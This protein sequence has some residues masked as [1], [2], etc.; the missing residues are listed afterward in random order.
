M[1]PDRPER[2]GLARSIVATPIGRLALTATAGGL[3]HVDLV[4]A[5]VGGVTP[6]V[7]SPVA[8]GHLRRAEEAL[9]NYFAGSVSAVDDVVVA[10]EGTDFQRAVWSALRTIPAGTTISYRQLA[11]RVGKRD[12]VR[13]VGLAN[14]RNPLPIIV[15]CHR[16]IGADR[17]LTGF[18]LGL[19][20]KAWLLVHE[21]AAE[22]FPDALTPRTVVVTR[23][24]L[25]GEDDLPAP[26]PA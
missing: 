24:I 5:D 13:A 19:A 22:P 11:E 20:V 10:P 8:A 7:G 16:V 21:G 4:A 9:A 18:G 1:L 12:A 23:R 25:W 2:P 6:S 17:S 26:P 3:A 15:P 14:G